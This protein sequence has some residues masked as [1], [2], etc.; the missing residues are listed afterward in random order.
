MLSQRWKNEKKKKQH[1]KHLAELS[2]L[3]RQKESVVNDGKEKN[4][5]RSCH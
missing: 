5:S 4:G 2:F 1:E 3:K